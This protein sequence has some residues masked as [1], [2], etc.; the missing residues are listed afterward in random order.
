MKLFK[1]LLPILVL[2]LISYS[3][4]SLNYSFRPEITPVSQKNNFY[5]KL[6]SAINQIQLDISQITFR[7]YQNQVEFYIMEDNNTSKVLLSTKKDP[8]WQ[9]ASLQ[10]VLKKS[11]I[12]GRK[13]YLIDLSIDNPYATF[14]NN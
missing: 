3:I 9:I 14:K 2:V 6:D 13:P 1:I 12:E 7:D 10:E 4:F 8:Y 11:K 5:T